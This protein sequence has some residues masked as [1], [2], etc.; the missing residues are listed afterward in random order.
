MR[1][2]GKGVEHNTKGG[3]TLWA[4]QQVQVEKKEKFWKKKSSRKKLDVKKKKLGVKET[5][6]R[7]RMWERNKAA[8]GTENT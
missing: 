1:Q 8:S 5:Q 6:R 4:L 2:E 3:K 7:G